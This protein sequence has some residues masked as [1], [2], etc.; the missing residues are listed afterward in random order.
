MAYQG[1]SPV[2]KT[3]STATQYFSGDGTTRQFTLTQGVSQASDLI[4]MVGSTLQI[5]GVNYTA[6]ST[7]ITFT[8]GNAPTAGTNNISVTYIAGNLTTLYCQCISGRN[9]RCSVNLYN[10]CGFNWDILA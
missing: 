8:V 7:T 1:L 6:A 5:P 2:N 3:L 4:V 10:G 9:Q